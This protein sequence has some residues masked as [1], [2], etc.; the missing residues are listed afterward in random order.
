MNLASIGAS[1]W[2]GVKKVPDIVWWLLIGIVF[3]KWV[4]MSSISRGKK[5]ERAAIAKKQAEVKAAVTERVTEIVSEERSSADAA[6]EARDNGP[7]FPHS[8]G[9]PDP[10][11][12]VIFRD[13]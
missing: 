13:T 7:S 3:F 10:L 12:R 2:T 9:V 8:D 5:E 4:E 11:Q 6:I 1:I